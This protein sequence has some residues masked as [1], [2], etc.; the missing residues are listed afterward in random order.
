MEFI[1]EFDTSIRL[2][3]DGNIVKALSSAKTEDVFEFAETLNLISKYHFRYEQK[4]NEN[5]SF[6]ANSSLSGGLHPCAAIQ[7]I[8]KKVD[9]LISF[10]SLYADEVYIQNP[11]EEVMLNGIDKLNEAARHELTNGIYIYFYLKPLI[12]AGVIKYAQN[13]LPFCSHHKETRAIPLSKEIER[14]ENI[15]NGFLQDNLIERCSVIFDIGADGGPFI[16]VIGPEGLIEHGK[17][18][19]HFYK[20]FPD[21]VK[22]LMKIKVP[23]Q[24]LKNEIKVW[25]ILSSNI[26]DPILRDLA[27]QE[28]HSAFYGTSYLCDNPTQM[29]LAS[30]L[31]GSAY[32]ASSSAFG[33]AMKH[34][35]P[36]VYSKDVQAIANL[37]ER[38]GEAFAV[39]RDKINSMIRK[40]GSWTEA[41]VSEIFRDQVL[42]EINLID[43][44]VKDWQSKT[45]TSIKE[46]I[47]FG[48]GAVSVGLYAG[49]LPP[50]IGQIV[51]AVGGGSAIATVLMDYNKTL[52]E[53]E[54]A[55]ASDFYFLWQATK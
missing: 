31:N 35:L 15:L 36:A 18:Y 26:I 17:M 37:R 24:L 16:E 38:E 5:F 11:F 22:A 42:P 52:K 45:R 27:N 53:K 4:P 7:C 39:Y 50:D 1:K 23:Y 49:L 6:I 51:A 14:K 20:P 30:K 46:K 10:A 28:W 2:F 33:N 19:F 12:E 55:R 34:Y 13:M 48:T 47:L 43:K 44:K 41:E 29:K 8:E 9:Q 32:K 54:E 21:Y 25:N 3:G 40:A